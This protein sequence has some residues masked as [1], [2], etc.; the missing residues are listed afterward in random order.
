MFKKKVSK[1]FQGLVAGKTMVK[2]KKLRK[3]KILIAS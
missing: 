1:L 2:M 3:Q